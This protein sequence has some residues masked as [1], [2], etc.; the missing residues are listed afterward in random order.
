MFTAVPGLGGVA[1][2]AFGLAAAAIAAR[3]PTPERWLAVW[4]ATAVVAF[5]RRRG[6]DLAEGRR[7][8]A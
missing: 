6:G 5:T 8:P 3:Q 4:L 1:M 7:E 2:G